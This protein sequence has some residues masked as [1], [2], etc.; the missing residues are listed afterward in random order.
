L[1]VVSATRWDTLGWFPR[2]T[3]DSIVK[4][5]L[6]EVA[7]LVGSVENLVVEDGEVQG[8][9]ETDGVGGGKLGLGNLGGGLV[10]LEGLVGGVLAAVADGELGQVAVVVA[11]PVVVFVKIGP[12]KRGHGALAYIL[13]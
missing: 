13:W 1:Y 11:L 10:G 6:G 7:S 12:K 8:E 4:G 9:A 2:L 5:L 3:S